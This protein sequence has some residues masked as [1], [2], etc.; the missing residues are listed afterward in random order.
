MREMSKLTRIGAII[1]G[2]ALAMVP[3]LQARTC[4]GN[5]DVIGSFGWMA[6]RAPEF[7]PTAITPPA[8]TSSSTTTTAAASSP[9]AGSNTPIG[10]LAAGAANSA[11]FA[12]VGRVF[13][14]GNGTVFAG[15]TPGASLLGVGTYTVNGDCTMSATI[16]DTFATPGGAGTT[17]VQASATFEGVVVQGGNEIDLTQTGTASGTIVTL[18]KTRQFCTIDGIASTFGISATGVSTLATVSTTGIAT[19]STTTSTPFT[20]VGRFVA[21]GAGNLIE[22]NIAI[23]SPLTNRQVTGSYTI[24][25]DCT[26]TATLVGADGKKRNANLVI[27]NQGSASNGPQAIEF[28]FSDAGVVGSGQAQQQ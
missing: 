7:V 27:V 23:A 8:T 11:A 2:G 22:D 17:P 10:T 19:V 1:L 14:D 25:L 26:G 6:V 21:D 12:S 4:G 16:T 18:R 5:S 13:L 24:N 9:L 3:A 28:A 20:I 15:S